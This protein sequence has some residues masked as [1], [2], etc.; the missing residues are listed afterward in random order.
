MPYSLARSPLSQALSRRR[1]VLQVCNDADSMHSLQALFAGIIG[2][3]VRPR[4][5]Q[6]RF[7]ATWFM[8]RERSLTECHVPD[9]YTYQPLTKCCVPDNAH[10]CI[11]CNR[12]HIYALMPGQPLGLIVHAWWSRC[13]RDVQQAPLAFRTPQL[14]HTSGMRKCKP[15]IHAHTK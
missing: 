11:T 4:G 12:S 13:M 5:P 15:L 6:T 8:D 1:S 3:E 10:C 2:Q 14:H 7:H 9:M